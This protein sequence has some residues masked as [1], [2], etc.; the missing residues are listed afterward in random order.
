MY[1]HRTPPLL[2]W[3]YPNLVW[4]VNTNNKDIYLTFDDGPIPEL[5][6][7][8]LKELDHWHAKATFFLVG[9]NVFKYPEIYDEIRSQGH[10]VGNHTYNHLNGWDNKN[11]EYIDN[12]N[13]CDSVLDLTTG[14]NVLFRLPYGKISFKQA[15][16][17]SKSHQIIMWDVLSGDFDRNL[18][19]EKCLENTIKATKKGSIVVFHDNVKTQNTL[20]AVLPKYLEHFNKLGYEFKS[21]V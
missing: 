4:R 18:S 7:W 19:P 5:T 6:L 8:V 17:I 1:F 15:K 14:A 3:L 13:R 12:I 21:I 9:E 16:L 11:Q 2:Q 10:S 20:K